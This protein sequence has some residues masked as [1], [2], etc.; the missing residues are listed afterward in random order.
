MLELAPEPAAPPSPETYIADSLDQPDPMVELETPP[1]LDE[2]PPIEPPPDVET[3]VTETLP[4]PEPLPDLP[5]SEIAEP[6]PVQRPER[7]EVKKEEPKPEKKKTPPPQVASRVAAPEKAETAKA[8]ET[9]AAQGSSMTP[10]R[11]Q[12][13]LMAHLERRKRYPSAARGR[14]EEGT[15]QVRFSIDDAGNVLSSQVVR[16]SGH[17]ALDDAV[18]DLMRR[19]SPVP[20]P[21]AG[22][23]RTITAPVRFNIR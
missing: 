18:V 5:P 19:A 15:V 2:P 23:P 16:S 13:K 22:A 4:E 10:A 7:L 1:P 11:W 3:P 17:P 14:G 6:R 21:P 8:P 20:P 12:S 9:V